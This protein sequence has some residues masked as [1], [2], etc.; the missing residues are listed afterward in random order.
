MHT[1]GIYPV[2]G[3]SA[4]FA[5]DDDSG[6]L[7][8]PRLYIAPHTVVLGFRDLGILDETEISSKRGGEVHTTG[9]PPDF[10]SKPSP[11]TSSLALAAKVMTNLS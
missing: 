5:P 7:L 1:R 9:P 3:C 11:M 6:T 2:P 10:S 8:L 4:F